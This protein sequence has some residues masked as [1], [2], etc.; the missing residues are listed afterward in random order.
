MDRDH[1]TPAEALDLA[2]TRVG[3]QSKLARL[4]KVS[5]PA[6]WG[7][8][9]KLKQLPAEHVLTVE[10]ATGVSRHDLRP[11]L[12]PRGL[13]DGVPFHAASNL[14]GVREPVAENRQGVLQSSGADDREKSSA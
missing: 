12:Y 13:E 3:S 9:N 4:C 8:L 2:T 5:Q 7:W 6:V 1:L 14:F 11:D 10:A